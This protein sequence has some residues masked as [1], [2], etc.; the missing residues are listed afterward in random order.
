MKKRIAIIGLGD[1]AQKVYV[2][3]LA[4][5]QQVEL[6]GVLSRTAATVQRVA[7]QY[8]IGGRF[9]S[10]EALLSVKPEAVFIHSSTETHYELVMECLK[11]GVAVYVDKPLSY[12]LGES[13]AMAQYALEQGVLL[14]V[15]FN[16]RFAP[17]YVKAKAWLETSGGLEL[18]VA[19]KHRT[20]LQKHSARHTVHD[21]LIHMLDLLLWLGGQEYDVQQYAERTDES[22]RLLTAAGS[23]IFKGLREG[24]DAY[25]QFSMARR[26]GADLE[27]LELHGSGRSAEVVN[28]ESA[29]LYDNAALPQTCGFGSWDSILYRRGFTGIIEHFLHSLDH[30]ESC[31]VRA[32]RVLAVHELADRLTS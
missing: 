4:A 20:K 2:P 12:N 13:A 11:Q 27:K 24:V 16:R 31:S 19:S 29:T 10:L 23:L 18:C 5:D 25:G 17:L 14:A 7:D 32:D 3:L 6:V 26:A 8:R 30:P 22:G 15:G 21:D 9:D 1:I 28:M